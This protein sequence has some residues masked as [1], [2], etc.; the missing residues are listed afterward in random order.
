MIEHF[1]NKILKHIYSQRHNAVFVIT[2]GILAICLCGVNAQSTATGLN[3]HQSAGVSCQNCHTETPPSIVVPDNQCLSC[4]GDLAQ[5]VEKT[6]KAYPNPHASPHIEP[7]NIP[8]CNDCHNIH[9]PST[10]NC[11]QCH[12]EFKFNV[13]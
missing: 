6:N 8:K 5:L 7:G 13:K 11:L 10:V 4:H 9:K 12:P 1:K 3:K 2:M